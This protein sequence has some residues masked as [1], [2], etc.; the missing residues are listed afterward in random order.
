MFK[1]RRFEIDVGSDYVAILQEKDAKELSL[2]PKNRIKIINKENKKFVLCALEIVNGPTT[3]KYLK[4]FN[5]KQ[6]EIGMFERAFD[7]LGIKEGSKVD[8]VP[9]QKPHSLEYIKLKAAGH[10]LKEGQLFDI[11]KDI[12][13]NRYSEIE[14]TYFVTACAIN[15]LNDAETIALTN[16]MV[17]I[18]KVLDFKTK[19]NQIIVDKHCIGG[20]PANRTTMIIVPIVA[21]AGLIIPKS[22]SRSITSPAGTADTMEVFANVDVPLSKMHHEV[23]ELGGCIV[24]GGIRFKP[25]R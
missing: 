23:K 14:T 2:Y 18:G 3:K 1:A 22:S 24:W 17:N 6:G 8:I 12:T 25:S 5:L 16:A 4:K 7:K 10:R 15:K 13:E 11:M 9:A 20:V 21:Y 19:N